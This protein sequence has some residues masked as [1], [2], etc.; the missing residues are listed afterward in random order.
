MR[1]NG[2]SATR[3]T[4]LPQAFT[5][6]VID[7]S[8]KPV[9]GVNVTFKVTGGGGNLGGSSTT[10]VASNVSGLAEATLTLGASAG[11][12]AVQVTSAGLAT[13]NLTATAQ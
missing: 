3:G 2:Q 12:N 8:G 7:V 6:R 11:A 4:T 9:S 13:L 1:G 5:V 10:T